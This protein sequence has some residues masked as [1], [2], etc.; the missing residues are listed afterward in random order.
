MTPSLP[1]VPSVQRGVVVLPKSVT[2]ERIVANFKYITLDKDD[3]DILNGL[4]KTK[5]NRAVKPPW[6]VDLGFPDWR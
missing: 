1:I 2:P 3:L 4:H 6:G 5:F